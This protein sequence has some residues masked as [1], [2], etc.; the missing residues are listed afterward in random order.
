MENTSV[1]KLF[2]G[3]IGKK[4]DEVD[5]DFLVYGIVIPA[6]ASKAVKEEA[7]L[8]YGKDA[9]MWN[10][11]LHKSWETVE[12]API[13][14]LV[15]Q[16]LM[17][18]FST[19]GLESL[20]VFSNETIYIPAEKLELPESSEDIEMTVIRPFTK[21]E[22][23]EKL[24]TLLTSGIA[25]SRTTIEA[26]KDLSDLIPKDRFDEIKNRE[27]KIFLYD[28]YNVVP[29]DAEEFLRYLIYRLT[30]NTTKIKDDNTLNKLILSDRKEALSLLDTYLNNG[31]KGAQVK[32]LAA[33]FNRNKKFFLALKVA[34]EKKMYRPSFYTNHMAESVYEKN[35]D[36]AGELNAIIN[37]ISRASKK[38][39]KPMKKAVLD[40]LT[41]SNLPVDMDKLKEMLDEITVYREIRILN[42]LSYRMDGPS[43]TVFRVR[44]GRSFAT[45]RKTLDRE[46]F[47][48]LQERYDFIKRHLVERLKPKFEGKTAFIPEYISYAAPTSEKQFVGMFPSQTTVRIPR[49]SDLIFGI[50]WFDVVTD[51]NNYR[52]DLDLHM[53]NLTQSFGWNSMWRDESVLF[54][55]DVTAAPKPNGAS[56]LY[57]ISHGVNET[58]SIS[59][60]NFTMADAKI[61]YEFVVAKVPRGFKKEKF[62]RNYMLDPKD[63]IQKVNLEID[64]DEPNHRIGM[65]TMDKNEMLFVFDDFAV[66]RSCVSRN[67]T[68]AF[69][70][71][72][73]YSKAYHNTIIS[74]KDLMEEAGC[75]F[76]D[77]PEYEDNVVV[78]SDNGDIIAK[79]VTKTVD[80]DLTPAKLDKETIIKMFN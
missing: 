49:D 79:K 31:E 51:K 36:C 46:Q 1:L 30:E 47:I 39:H 7:K 80:F 5:K 6:S 29:S 55:G 22:V 58:Y 28:K 11:T 64:G 65:V 9:K 52:I 10:Q 25:L 21:K 57:Y 68:E 66:E 27:V 53:Q 23:S 18:Y 70:H 59:L 4:A 48:T 38:Y 77:E 54:S 12:E 34:E 75:T 3:Y 26:I 76:K 63:I 15:A 72:L 44:N 16:Q 74:L 24:M 17:H 37:E 19:Y 42:G 32:K 43:D 67:N 41:D 60:N 62:T 61:P 56:E 50:H 69:A 78:V 20:G 13:E 73:E 45:E 14:T 71:A 40:C 8:L 35:K 2:K 33:I